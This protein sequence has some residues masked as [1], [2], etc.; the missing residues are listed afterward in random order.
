MLNPQINNKIILI[1]RCSHDDKVKYPYYWMEKVKK[2]AKKL[3]FDVIDLKDINF[4]RNKLISM[5]KEKQ[6]FMVILCGHGNDS[7]VFG[8]NN[9]KVM[10]LCNEDYLLKNKIVYVISCYTANE[11]SKSA[12]N[13]GCKHYIG[14]DILLDIPAKENTTPEKDDYAQPCMEAMTLLP[15]SILKGDDIN[16]AY[17]KCYDKFNEWIRRWNADVKFSS[18]VSMLEEIR[19]HILIDA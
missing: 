18:M 15:I 4:D 5:L 2:E 9:Q 14:W 7:S 11:L 16:M 19:D 3:G 10:E 8:H 1:G 12:R 6:P 17:N 13:K